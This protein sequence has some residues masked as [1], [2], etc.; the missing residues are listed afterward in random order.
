MVHF[1][2]G[3]IIEASTNEW[4]I[5]KQLFKTSDKSAYH[6]LGEVFAQRCLESGFIEM[7][8]IIRPGKSDKVRDFLNVVKKS[9]II[10]KEFGTVKPDLSTNPWLGRKMKPYGDWEEH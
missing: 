3:P 5:K 7:A 2:K 9:G 6:N 1:E 10:L 8:C 4:A